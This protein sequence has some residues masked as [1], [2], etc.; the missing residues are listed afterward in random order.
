MKC[1]EGKQL[2]LCFTALLFVAVLA[3]AGHVGAATFFGHDYDLN[4]Y[5]IDSVGQTV[6]LLGDAGGSHEVLLERL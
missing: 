1:A 4:V 6:T 5:L 3:T 2:A